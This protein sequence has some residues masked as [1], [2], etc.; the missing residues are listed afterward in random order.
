MM[1]ITALIEG[2]TS[3][4]IIDMGEIGITTA[5]MM[6]IGIGTGM[7]SG[8]VGVIRPNLAHGGVSDREVRRAAPYVEVKYV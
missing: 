8:M 3:A 2:I 1:A 7:W 4:W 6:G 5:I